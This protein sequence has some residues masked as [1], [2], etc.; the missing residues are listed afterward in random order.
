MRTGR[1]VGVDNRHEPPAAPDEGW[2]ARLWHEQADRDPA[3]HTHSIHVGTV[4]S[5]LAREI[6]FSEEDVLKVQ[7][8]S[9]FHDIGKLDIPREILYAPRRLTPEERR[10]VELHSI[11]GSRRLRQIGETPMLAFVEDVALHH[12]ERFDGTGY[13]EKLAGAQISLPAR[14][15][16]VG[17]VYAALWERRSYKAAMSH[18]A[19]LASMT[20]G[21]ERMSPAMFDPQVLD[22]LKT[23]MPKL[24]Q[25]MAE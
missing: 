5:L 19:V 11:Y 21:D 15:A 24:K 3:L 16:T 8:A 17:D 2:V 25:A 10:L 1:V 18:D 4:A 22:A 12:H 13:P 6:G 23:S 14:I 9:L 7:L 20:E